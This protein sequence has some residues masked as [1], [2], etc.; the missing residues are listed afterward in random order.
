MNNIIVFIFQETLINI[1]STAMRTLRLQTAHHSSPYLHLIRLRRE[2]AV[3]ARTCVHFVTKL[4]LS[5]FPRVIFW[6]FFAIIAFVCSMSSGSVF[7]ERWVRSMSF[8]RRLFG[9]TWYSRYLPNRSLVW[10]SSAGMALKKMLTT[11]VKVHCTAR[12]IDW[13]HFFPWG[14]G[15]INEKLTMMQVKIPIPARVRTRLVSEGVV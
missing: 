2:F 10:A 1:F 15:G 5:V 14:L 13:N 6:F 12:M 11:G 8:V 4:Y 7:S 3:F 9:V